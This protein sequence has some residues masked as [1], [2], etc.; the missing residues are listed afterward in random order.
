MGVLKLFDRRFGNTGKTET[1]SSK[2]AFSNQLDRIPVQTPQ[3]GEGG[4][5]FDETI[6]VRDDT[7]GNKTEKH[8]TKDDNWIAYDPGS[9]AKENPR[10]PGIDDGRWH[11]NL[12]R[13]QDALPSEREGQVIHK[14]DAR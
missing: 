3:G 9:Q 2:G 7:G 11:E 6:N 13:Q 1:T 4:G 12:R 10:R 5:A 14:K 8:D